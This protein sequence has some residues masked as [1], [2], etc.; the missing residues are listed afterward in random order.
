[1]ENKK[2]VD[3]FKLEKIRDRIHEMPKIHHEYIFKHII[4][5]GIYGEDI[6]FSENSSGIWLVMNKLNT[7]VINDIQNYIN[8]VDEQEKMLINRELVKKQLHNE[9]FNDCDNNSKMDDES[10][11]KET[12]T[13][14]KLM[15]VKKKIS[16]VKSKFKCKSNNT[17]ASEEYC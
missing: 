12:Q 1:M 2:E 3:Y 8:H 9:Y 17:T 11:K 6:P 15:N 7:K 5:G 10:N 16:N 13:V 14:K 4:K